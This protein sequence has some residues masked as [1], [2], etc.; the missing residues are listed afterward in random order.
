MRRATLNKA[1]GIPH[2]NRLRCLVIVPAG[3]LPIPACC[4]FSRLEQWLTLTKWWR[5]FS[6]GKQFL[7][8]ISCVEIDLYDITTEAISM[9]PFELYD[10]SKSVCLFAANNLK[11]SWKMYWL[12][13]QLRHVMS[14][15]GHG[16][17]LYCPSVQTYP[18]IA[19][20]K[21]ES[22][23][24]SRFF[25]QDRMLCMPYET[26]YSGYSVIAP[27]IWFENL[28]N[29]NAVWTSFPR[30]GFWGSGQ[31]LLRPAGFIWWR[32]YWLWTL[33]SRNEQKKVRS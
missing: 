31:V 13:C 28:A 14:T 29:N 12:A 2:P 27:L 19:R 17:K 21:F 9:T 25:M 15:G 7:N 8:A 32:Y 22:C 24:W 18:T 4:C 33:T 1:W 10:N 6:D 11:I 26:D 3:H 20:H 16:I 5:P 23:S 30:Y